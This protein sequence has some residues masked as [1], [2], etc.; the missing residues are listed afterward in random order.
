MTSRTT[1][2]GR[3]ASINSRARDAIGRFE[4]LETV[5]AEVPHDDVAY[6]ALV[7]DHQNPWLASHCA[8]RP[9]DFRG[10]ASAISKTVATPASEGPSAVVT[11]ALRRLEVVAGL[12]SK[13]PFCKKTTDAQP[14]S[15]R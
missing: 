5:M 1:R 13:L 9:G 8:E 11:K 3:S 12:R 6:H 15:R 14:P 10:W 7:V 2:S 4:G